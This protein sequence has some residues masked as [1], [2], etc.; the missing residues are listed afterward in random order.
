ML[1]PTVTLA[2]ETKTAPG[3]TKLI[4]NNQSTIWLLLISY[5]LKTE[6]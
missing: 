4:F 5:R 2:V 1:T 3:N 6:D